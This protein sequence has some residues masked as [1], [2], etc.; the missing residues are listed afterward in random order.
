MYICCGFACTA[1]ARCAA[2]PPRERQRR[3]M[4]LVR[5]STPAERGHGTVFRRPHLMRT[6]PWPTAARSPRPGRTAPPRRRVA[7][8]DEPGSHTTP[9]N[10]FLLLLGLEHGRRRRVRARAAALT[11]G[12]GVARW[13]GERNSC[14]RSRDEAETQR[15]EPTMEALHGN[16]CGLAS[17]VATAVNRGAS[18]S[19]FP[20]AC[21]RRSLAAHELPTC[22]PSSTS[23]TSMRRV[24][25]P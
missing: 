1:R 22:P 15:K 3:A 6:M 13:H 25:A 11:C 10:G 23:S 9:P 17:E 14:A 5:S 24:A 19:R 20:G 12:E 2:A 16:S 21:R 18:A 4:A 8:D 7:V